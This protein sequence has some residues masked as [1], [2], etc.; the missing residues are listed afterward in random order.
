MSNI[1][2]PQTTPYMTSQDLINSVQRK[3]SFPISQQTFSM[4]DILAFANEEVYISQVPSILQFHS[5][6]FVTYQTIPLLTNVSNYPIPSRAIGQKLR[7]VF[8]QDTSGNMFEMTQVAEEDR[9]FYQRNI[10][11]NQ[12]IHKFFIEGNSI[13][14]TPGMI[15]NPTGNLILVYYLRPNQLVK[16]DRA[17][18]INNFQQTITLN[19]SLIHPLDVITIGVD[20]NPAGP[21]VVNIPFTAVASVGGT[22]S[23]IVFNST[24]STLITTSVPHQLSNFQTVVI[25]GSNSNPIVDGNWPVTVLSPTTFTIPVQ[26]ATSGSAGTFTCLNQFLIAATGTLTAANLATSINSLQLPDTA[27]ALAN[28]VTVSFPNIY[29]ILSSPNTTGFIIPTTYST[30]NQI[31]NAT[32]GINFQTLP[33]TYTDQETNVTSPLFTPGTLIDLL[34]TNP[35]HRTYKYDVLIP[36]TGISGTVITI[37][38]SSL[39]IPSG[40]VNTIP[41]VGIQYMIAPLIPGDYICLANECIIPQ[42]PPDLHNGLAERTSAR[43]L[44]ALG[45]QAGLAASN[46]KIQEIDQRQGNL[47]S[48]RD[49]GNVQKVTGRHSLLHQGML[50]RFRRM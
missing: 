25:S 43:I 11:T 50:G 23:S 10:G 38:Q 35:G 33:T 7:S 39:L 40:T 16:N 1:I 42:I 36:Q 32:I 5:E 6:Y 37:P 45:D 30:V 46:A 28:I 31:T 22:I 17:A 26:I 9:A 24:T 29:T 15:S 41:N 14:L 47:M 3:M 48:T 21:G 27:V 12:A 44:A 20:G 49:D 2:I 19:N 18:I 13:V 34:Q 4:L 8:W